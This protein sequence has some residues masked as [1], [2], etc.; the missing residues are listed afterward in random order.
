MYADMYRG[1]S[2]SNRGSLGWP[3]RLLCL[4]HSGLRSELFR[5]H[6]ALKLGH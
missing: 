4:D 3:S 6:P 1:W 2:D 5:G